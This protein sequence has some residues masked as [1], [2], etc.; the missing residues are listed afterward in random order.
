MDRQ[1]MINIALTGG[2]AT[3]VM[4]LWGVLQ[5]RLLRIPPL[6]YALVGRWILWAA[7]GRIRHSTI[8]STP[9]MSREV[10]LG[11]G[12]HYLTGIL[13]AAI[14]AAT[15]GAGWFRHPEFQTALLAGAITLLAPFCIL[16]PAF[17]FG[18]AASRTPHPWRARLLSVLA[19][20]A[21]GCG[22]YLSA[23]AL[24]ALC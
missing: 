6:N 3:L 21:F 15:D 9:A 22:L 23:T 19:H 5:Q 2:G 1:L 24:N 10:A 16:Q 20:L 11:W 8:I 12:A 14:P 18:I 4:D 17:G 7:R 13:F